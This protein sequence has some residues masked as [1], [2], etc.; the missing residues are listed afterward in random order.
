MD[1]WSSGLL[2][3]DVQSY[4]TYQT[5]GLLVL[6]N[7]LIY[8]THSLPTGFTHNQQEIVIKEVFFYTRLTL[9]LTLTLFA[10]IT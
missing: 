5:Q 9:T 7:I 4:S 3:I 8:F 10:N 6:R 2:T 1:F